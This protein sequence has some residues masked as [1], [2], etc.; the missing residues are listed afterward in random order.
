MD[1]LL[2]LAIAVLLA[3]LL[4]GHAR[5]LDIARPNQRRAYQLAA[6]AMVLVAAYNTADITG[7]SD[8]LR[9][10]VVGGAVVIALVATAVFFVRGYFAGEMTADHE[11][12]REMARTYR[13]QRE[14]EIDAS[15]RNG[16]GR[17]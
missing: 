9:Q 6:L 3:V 16:S 11:R 15:R 5:R 12:A 7:L 13:E 17:A 14:R 8:P 1:A 2:R 10:S 4:F